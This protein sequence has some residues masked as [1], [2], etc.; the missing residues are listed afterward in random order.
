V[1]GSTLEIHALCEECGAK[2][3]KAKRPGKPRH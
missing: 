2:R 3:A 1:I